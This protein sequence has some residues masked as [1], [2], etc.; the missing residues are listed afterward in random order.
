MDLRI[1]VKARGAPWFITSQLCHDRRQL[2]AYR[3][4]RWMSDVL[5]GVATGADGALWFPSVIVVLVLQATDDIDKLT[6]L[7]RWSH[8]CREIGSPISRVACQP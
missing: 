2:A 3:A 6:S 7:Q 1:A 5:R 4:Q 8:P